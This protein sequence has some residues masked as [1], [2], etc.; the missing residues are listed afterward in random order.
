MRFRR[1]ILP[2]LDKEAAASLAEDA[3]LEPFLALM[4]SL[5]GILDVE[6]ALE[7][8]SGW[9]VTA[10]PLGFADMDKAAARIRRA[11]DEGERIL[12]Y[13]DYDADGVTSTVLLYSYLKERGADV[14][15]MLPEREG[16]GYGLHKSSVDRIAE[17]G[18]RLI[19]TVDNGV[20]AVEEIA[21][22]GEKGL[23]VVVTDHHQ[24]QETLPNAV[25]VVDPHRADCPSEFKDYAGVGVA[26]Q[27]VCAL[28]GDVESVLDRYADLVA[29]GTLA[30]VMPLRGENRV[31]VRHGLRMLS[32]G[33][34]LGFRKLAEISGMAGKTQ[35]STAAVFSLA[36]RINAAGRMGSPD[37]AAELLLSEREEEAELLAHEIQSLNIRRQETEASILADVL[38]KLSCSPERLHDRILVV[39]GEGWHPGVVGI[40]AARLTERYGRPS[41]VLSVADGLA[42]GSG[43]SLKGFSLFAALSACRDCLLGFGGHELA[44]GVTLDFTRIEE[45]RQAVNAYAAAVCPEM[46]VPELRL[47][48][49]LRPGQICLPLLETLGAMEPYGTG[50]PAPLFG[51]FGM[52]L[53]AVTPVCGGK[54]LRLRLSRD[55]T[56]LTAMKFGTAP[57]DFHFVPGD[58]VNLAVSLDRNEYQGNVT[59]SVFVKDIRYA[60][61][62]QD[63]ILASMQEAES[64]FRKELSAPLP[65]PTRDQA[66]RVYRFLAGKKG[67]RGTGEQLFHILQDG[68]LTYT[69]LL[70]TLEVLR[71]AGLIQLEDEGDL[72]QIGLLP[73]AGKADLTAT[74]LMQYLASLQRA[75]TA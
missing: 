32:E 16:E 23:D 6:E 44:A 46:P 60:S 12:V 2:E 31:L 27:L 45:F 25:A 65:V 1:W 21:Y 13:G 50:N 20:S 17:A 42:K 10:D 48:C 67:F 43:R 63:D 18:V 9:D 3:G 55:G 35:T 68:S 29:M 58:Q 24:P 52:T 74:P 59:V 72:L 19:V 11:L 61:T 47:D 54:H 62:R 33:S 28:E 4:L 30:D 40:I 5:R 39:A 36:P 26:F 64:A 66:G 14:L 22:A 37:K 73:T 57:Q 8:L 69:G 7:F 71:Q 38:K 34:R 75:E 53:E 41:M 15:Y 56:V 70:L 49:K 51:L